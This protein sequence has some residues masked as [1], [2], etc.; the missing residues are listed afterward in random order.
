M[1]RARA[2]SFARALLC[3]HC[4]E[5]GAFLLQLTKRRC[6]HKIEYRIRPFDFVLFSKHSTEMARWP[7]FS[8]IPNSQS[9]P[10]WEKAL[11]D[12]LAAVL[13][14]VFRTGGKRAPGAAS[15]PLTMYL[16]EK[17]CLLNSIRPLRDF[18][19]STCPHPFAGGKPAPARPRDTTPLTN[20]LV[21]CIE[22]L[23]IE[24]IRTGMASAGATAIP[25]RSLRVV[26]PTSSPT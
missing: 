4:M 17:S 6:G 7:N 26:N 21:S 11:T 20:F 2:Q 10:A 9:T 5:T 25:G 24:S 23:S 1:L 12:A 13:E 8:K 18:A 22:G 19:T 3:L 14:K 16:E 15:N